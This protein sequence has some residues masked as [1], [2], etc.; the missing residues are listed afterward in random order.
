[1]TKV[2]VKAA[3]ASMMVL[4]VKRMLDLEGLIGIVVVL[5]VGE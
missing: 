3:M 2:A 4:S 1:M 5:V